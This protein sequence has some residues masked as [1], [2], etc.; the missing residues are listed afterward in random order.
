[1]HL[2]V[3]S[4]D[5]T[6]LASSGGTRGRGNVVRVFDVAS[7]RELFRAAEDYTASYQ[8]PVA[9]SDDGKQ[10]AA[11]HGA[12]TVRVW[13]LKAGR[14]RRRGAGGPV[15]GTDQAQPRRGTL[16]RDRGGEAA[17]V[18]VAQRLVERVCHRPGRQVGGVRVG[19]YRRRGDRPLHRPRTPPA[20][21]AHA[22]S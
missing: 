10:L 16:G 19:R 2:L 4:P 15:P 3:F 22:V 17:C 7:G 1:S 6:R 20:D 13:A 21:G 5:G 11:A 12:R 18:P 9:F 8:K 14:E